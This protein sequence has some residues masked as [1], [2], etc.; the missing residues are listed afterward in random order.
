[1][2]VSVN[3]DGHIGISV[4]A[5]SLELEIWCEFVASIYFGDT[6]KDIAVEEFKGFAINLNLRLVEFGSGGLS[7]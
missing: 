2:D 1:M 6:G 7:W 5:L 3:T 4:V